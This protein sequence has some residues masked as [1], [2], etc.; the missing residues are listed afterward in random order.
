MKQTE[1]DR[2][3][4]K[5]NSLKEGKLKIHLLNRHVYQQKHEIASDPNYN[6]LAF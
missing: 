3:K 6:I 2:S 5:I 4:R 1:N